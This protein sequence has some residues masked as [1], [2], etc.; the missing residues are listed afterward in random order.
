MISFENGI[1]LFSLNHSRIDDIHFICL[2]WWS[3]KPHTHPTPDAMSSHRL[4]L[5]C[6]MIMIIIEKMVVILSIETSKQNISLNG[7]C[8]NIE[9]DRTHH[10]PLHIAF[11]QIKFSHSLFDQCSSSSP[12]FGS[13]AI[14]RHFD[15]EAKFSPE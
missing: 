11:I 12:Y 2:D 13:I 4:Q 7:R 8:L 10:Y 15:D 1:N 5:E 6:V 3:C 14:D 9:Q